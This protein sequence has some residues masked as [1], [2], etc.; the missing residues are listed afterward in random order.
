MKQVKG[1]ANGILK[2][3]TMSFA[4]L[5]YDDSARWIIFVAII[6]AIASELDNLI[7]EE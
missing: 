4:V 5:A 6:I 1:M 2:A 3:I 7:G